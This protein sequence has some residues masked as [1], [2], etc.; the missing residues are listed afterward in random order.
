MAAEGALELYKVC[1]SLV[2]GEGTWF[3]FTLTKSIGFLSGK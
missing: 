2:Q 1:A 3:T